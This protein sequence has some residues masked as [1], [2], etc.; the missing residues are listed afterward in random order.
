MRPL[1][2][3]ALLLLCLAA[4]LVGFDGSKPPQVYFR[5]YTQTDDQGNT[6]RTMS[7]HVIN[8]EQQ[9]FVSTIPEATE[10]DIFGIEP[11]AAD[12]G[13]MGAVFHLNAHAALNVDAATTQ[14]DGKILVFALNGRVLYNPIIDSIVSDGIL[15]VPRGITPQEIALLQAVVK[16]NLHEMKR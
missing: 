6:N 4:W 2:R 11:F 12:G 5:I 15:R 3:P 16:Q 10:K 1:P 8:P 7:V 9:I 14:Y 13:T